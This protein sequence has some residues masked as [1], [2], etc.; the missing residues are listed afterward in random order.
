MRGDIR[1][2]EGRLWRHD[3]QHDDPDLETDIGQCPEC[4]GKDCQAMS[5]HEE[6]IADLREF[7]DGQAD[8]EYFTE[9]PQPQPNEAMRLLVR[10]NELFPEEGK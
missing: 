6:L 10:L 1:C 8:A 7:L 2:F 4:E 9:S 3:P 5:D